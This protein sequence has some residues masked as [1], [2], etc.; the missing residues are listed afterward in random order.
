MNIEW[1]KT[2]G[3]YRGVELSEENFQFRSWFLV[4]PAKAGLREA[5]TEVLQAAFMGLHRRV[6][7]EARKEE[8]LSSLEKFLEGK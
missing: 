2:L 6:E 8:I 4:C 7:D 5:G 1:R 3:G